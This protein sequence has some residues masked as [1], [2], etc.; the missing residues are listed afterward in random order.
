MLKFHT[1]TLGRWIIFQ[2]WIL[3]MNRLQEFI[4]R[5]GNELGVRVVAPYEIKVG[6]D[7]SIKVEAWLPQLGMKHGMLIVQSYDVISDVASELEE[8]GYGCSIYS[9]PL[10][11]EEFDIESYIEMFCDWGWADEGE[12]RPAWME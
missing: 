7:K 1:A 10:P 5:A 9:E 6:A 11:T 3:D 8:Q 2:F 12:P 4:V